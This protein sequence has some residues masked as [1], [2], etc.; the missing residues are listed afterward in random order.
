MDKAE[1]RLRLQRARDDGLS[2]TD[3][4]LGAALVSAVAETVEGISNINTPAAMLAGIQL[5]LALASVDS[6]AGRALERT[7]N[8]MLSDDATNVFVRATV[9]MLLAT[10]R[11]RLGREHATSPS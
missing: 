1:I 10:R 4:G 7:L 5:G 3:I 2:E 8:I 9:P 11:E 6:E